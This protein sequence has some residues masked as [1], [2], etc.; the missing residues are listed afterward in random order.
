MKTAAEMT[1]CGRR[2][3]P[4]PDFPPRPQPLEIAMRFPHSRSRDAQWKSGKP[5]P[6][7]PL[8]HCCGFTRSSNFKTK[9][10]RPEARSSAPPFRLILQ[11]ENAAM[12]GVLVFN[13]FVDWFPPVATLASIPPRRRYRLFSPRRPGI[14]CHSIFRSYPPPRS[15]GS[16]ALRGG[17]CS[18]QWTHPWTR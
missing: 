16:D 13:V 9:T 6:R 15:A 3:K 18:P 12:I 1:G 11:L 4:K 7:F 17:E 2:G 8:S 10:R 5:K 14:Q